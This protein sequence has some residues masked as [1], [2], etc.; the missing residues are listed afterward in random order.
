MKLGYS[1]HS[2][3]LRLRV[4]PLHRT[5]SD[6]KVRHLKNVARGK[7]NN[8]ASKEHE[9]LGFQVKHYKSS[10][11]QKSLLFIQSTN[12]ATDIINLRESEHKFYKIEIKDKFRVL[13]NTS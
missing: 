11:N 2:I 7:P 13:T 10:E 5:S 1:Q 3:W 6:P 4:K 12:H 9:C 8:S